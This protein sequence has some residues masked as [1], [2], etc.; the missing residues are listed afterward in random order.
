MDEN[1]EIAKKNKLTNLHFFGWVEFDQLL[2][3]I[4]K[5]DACLGI[6]GDGR[7]HDKGDAQDGSGH[8]RQKV[9]AERFIMPAKRAEYGF[10][11]EHNGHAG[12]YGGG[13]EQHHKIFHRL[14]LIN[15]GSND[16]LFSW[17]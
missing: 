8:N 7:A 15:S 17:G 12:S 16:A 10:R 4:N 9:H 1:R 14:P 3:N 13:A 5:S 2:E 6:F 11:V